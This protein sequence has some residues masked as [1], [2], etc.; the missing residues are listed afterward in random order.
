MGHPF[1]F[2]YVFR[3]K[4]LLWKLPFFHAYLFSFHLL[5]FPQKF[6]LTCVFFCSEYPQCGRDRDWENRGKVKAVYSLFLLKWVYWPD[7]IWLMGWDNQPWYTFILF[8]KSP[9]HAWAR[10]KTQGRS[11]S[12]ERGC[13]HEVKSLRQDM[14]PSGWLFRNW[15]AGSCLSIWKLFLRHFCSESSSGSGGIDKNFGLEGS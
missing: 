11:C 12:L 7:I 6:T 15:A 2:F 13:L 1:F 14:V 5:S 3:F 4:I 9:R 10:P 8:P